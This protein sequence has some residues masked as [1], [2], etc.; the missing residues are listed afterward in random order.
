[1]DTAVKLPLA[2]RIN[3]R[4][5][6][7][8]ATIAVIVGYPVYVLV[9]TQL[10]RGIKDAGGGYLEVNLKSMSTFSFDQVNGNLEEIPEHYR[11]LDGKK[12]VLKGEMWSPMGAGDEVDSF[13]LV[14][15]IAKCCISGKPLVQHL[16]ISKPMPGRRI[17]FYSGLVEARG[18]LH[19]EVK[20]N[21]EGVE[22]IYTFD[23]ES[24]RPV[25]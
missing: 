16:V 18:V 8:I 20:K 3:F 12:V 11:A 21:A 23:V 24:V 5:L 25:G 15:S 4:M 19:V 1:M 6:F 7:F 9:D 13:V 17:A 2:E 22:S 14:Y 10:S